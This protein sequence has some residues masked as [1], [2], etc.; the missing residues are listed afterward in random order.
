VYN[1][2]ENI[3]CNNM[4]TYLEAKFAES[5]SSS[6]G[7][8]ELPTDWPPPEQLYRLAN[9]CGRFLVYAETATRFIF[10]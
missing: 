7:T 3:T 8:P 10:E 5:A 1:I 4:R 6:N 9:C 2:D